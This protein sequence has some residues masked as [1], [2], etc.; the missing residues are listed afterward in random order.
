MTHQTSK[1]LMVKEIDVVHPG[2]FNTDAGAD[3]SN[4]RIRIGDVLL[5]GI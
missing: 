4:A 3:F 5:A 2:V 1:L